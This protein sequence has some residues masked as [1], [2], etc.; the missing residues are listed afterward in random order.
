MASSAFVDFYP[1]RT[2]TYYL[3]RDGVCNASNGASYT[4][5]VNP[6]SKIN[7]ARIHT[8]DTVFR[9][10]K[11]AINITGGSLGKDA[12]WYWYKDTCLQNK[13]IGTGDTIMIRVKKPTKFLVKAIGL[14]NET[15]YI[16]IT[17]IPYKPER[18]RKKA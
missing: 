10:I 8:P 5:H 1:L 16:Q 13:F 15:E 3:H 9:K 11:T 18:K 12:N 17:I 7:N 6:K 4:I 2:T 14:C